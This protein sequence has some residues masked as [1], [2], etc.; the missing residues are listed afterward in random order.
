LR[1]IQ[2]VRSQDRAR[3]S[4]RVKTQLFQRLEE[5]PWRIINIFINLSHVSEASKPKLT[6]SSEKYAS[7]STT[8]IQPGSSVSARS[9]F[10]AGKRGRNFGRTGPCVAFGAILIKLDWDDCDTESMW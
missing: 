9:L 5:L 6:K 7:F 4:L 2:D 1:V 10:K 3:V 8:E